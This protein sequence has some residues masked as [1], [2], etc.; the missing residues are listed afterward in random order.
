[1]GPGVTFFFFS[2]YGESGRGRGLS[3]IIGRPAGVLP[4]VLGKSINYD[5]RGRVGGLI[6]MKHHVLGGLN[7]LP[8]VEPAYLWLWQAGHGCMKARHLPV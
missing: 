7:R 5:E 4:C 8:V 2:G 1:M 3:S 6:K